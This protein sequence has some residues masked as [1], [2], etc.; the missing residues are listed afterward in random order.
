MRLLQ[1]AS[2]NCAVAQVVVAQRYKLERR[3]FDF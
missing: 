1:R 2:T 3:G